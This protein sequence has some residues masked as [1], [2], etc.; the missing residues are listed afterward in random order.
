MKYKYFSISRKRSWYDRVTINISGIKITMTL[1]DW[2]KHDP[3]AVLIDNVNQKGPY[4]APAV[5]QKFLPY[6]C[7]CERQRSSME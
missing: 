3:C 6:K 1:L 7:E 4:V 2:Y 5:Y